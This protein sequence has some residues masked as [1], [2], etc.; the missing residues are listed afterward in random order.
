MFKVDDILQAFYEPRI[1][2]GQLLDTFYGITFFECLGKSE[3][4]EICRV[5]EFF[6]EVIEVDVFVTYEAM[7]ALA[8]H[9]Q[10][11][12]QHLFERTAD[13]HNLTY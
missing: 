6:V 8:Y 12:L 13:A 10:A 7:H 11:L 9:S 3:D 2:L 1:Y 5:S 4:T